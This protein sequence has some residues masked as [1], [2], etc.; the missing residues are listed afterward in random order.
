MFRQLSHVDRNPS[1]AEPTNA[2][3]HYIHC[4]GGDHMAVDGHGH[5]MTTPGYIAFLTALA[6]WAGER[7]YLR[8]KL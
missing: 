4:S 7:L 2:Y 8:G 3:K 1:G 5:A 6:L